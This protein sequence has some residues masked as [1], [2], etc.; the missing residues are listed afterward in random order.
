[1]IDPLE[2]FALRDPAMALHLGTSKDTRLPG[3]QN[4]G[5]SRVFR[6]LGFEGVR[7]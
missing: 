5:L 3:I 6:N 7:V 4:L 1:M 2:A